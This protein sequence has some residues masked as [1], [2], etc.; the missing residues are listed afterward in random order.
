M[1]R[2][3]STSFVSRDPTYLPRWVLRMPS[4]VETRP[5]RDRVT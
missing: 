4:L 2:K 1:R 3:S 5:Q